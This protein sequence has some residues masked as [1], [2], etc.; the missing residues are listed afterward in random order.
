MKKLLVVV[1]AFA[2]STG[3]FAQLTV[4]GQLHTQF[5]IDVFGGEEQRNWADRDPDWNFQFIN[6]G[7][8]FQLNTQRE[9]TRGFLRLRSD[10]QWRAE[11][12][13]V[14]NDFE[15]GIGF[16]EL[17]WVRWSAMNINNNSNAGIGAMNSAVAPYIIGRYVVGQG[18]RI[19]AGLSEGGMNTGSRRALGGLLG[20][21]A[22][23]DIE[24][25]RSGV[26][27]VPVTSDDDSHR[28]FPGF[29][30]GFDHIEPGQFEVALAFAGIPR[31]DITVGTEEGVFP[32]MIGATGRLFNLGPVSLLG[33]NIAIYQDPQ[34]GFFAVGHG[35]F[36]HVARWSESG[37][38]VMEAMLDV[39]VPTPVGLLALSYGILMPFEEN[40]DA[41][42]M[43]VGAQINIPFGNGFSFIP[44]VLFQMDS[45]HAGYSRTQ[46]NIGAALRFNF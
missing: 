46:T 3:A 43:Q 6:S 9:N 38:M 1:L 39:R 40:S 28:S 19:Y 2:V 12:W 21:T 42:A 13:Q 27:G 11:I 4:S 30:V 26:H 24:D 15:L 18:T 8:M 45:N 7:T 32:F 10:F 34:W 17:P 37:F 25:P 33:L 36:A 16:I 14:L 20:L 44:G 5:G 22:A 23:E 41:L 31:P 35:G 29:F